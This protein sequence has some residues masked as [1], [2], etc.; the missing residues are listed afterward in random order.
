VTD[1]YEILGVSKD[2]SP[3]EVKSAYRKLA[4][5]LHPDLNPADK[6]AEA[7]FKEVAA[8]FS[9]LGDPEKRVQYDRGEI[10]AK[11]QETPQQQYYKHYAEQNP[12]RQYSS[13][14]S[15]E[16]LG[17]VFSDLFGR[18]AGAGAEFKMRG[19][20]VRYHLAVEFEGAA[21]G[22]TKRVT[23][24]DGSTIDVQV[25]E[26]V[27]M[28]QTIR[29]RGKGQPGHGGGPSGDAF[30][31]IEVL[32]HPVFTRDGNDI[33]MTLPIS[34]DEAILGAKVEVPTLDGRVRVTVPKGSS[35]GQILKLKGKGVMSKGTG[36]RGNQKCTLKIVLP[37][38]VDEDLSA[39][40][41]EWRATHAY[42]PRKD[43]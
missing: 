8:A 16:D 23:L 3:S 7:R 39:F 2:A 31:E 19:R 33:D 34:I 17:G 1:L 28:G 24:A 38:S 15:F 36:K 27:A 10:D 41:T 6:T 40:L 21:K 42:N 13:N 18:G 32:P 43:L 26:G 35:G 22:A 9:I 11:G 12:G 14:A 37:E 25:P 20:D 30:V 4:K 5:K 29:L